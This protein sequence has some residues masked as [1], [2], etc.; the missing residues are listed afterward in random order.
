LEV[1][2]FKKASDLDYKQRMVLDP[3]IS[4]SDVS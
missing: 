4:R 2:W 3:I 1:K